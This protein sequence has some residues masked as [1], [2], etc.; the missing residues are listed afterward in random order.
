MASLHIHIQLSD[1]LKPV[2]PCRPQ[3]TLVSIGFNSLPNASFPI[4]PAELPE[5]DT[6]RERANI[7][8]RSRLHKSAYVL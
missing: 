3:Q 4:A 2:T 8:D 5:A 1:R 7:S 6:D